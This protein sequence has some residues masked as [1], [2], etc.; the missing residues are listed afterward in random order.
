M[1]KANFGLIIGT[2]GFFN[3]KLAPE[4][5]KALLEKLDKLGYV[6]VTLDE[7]A[8]PYGAVETVEN[9]KK[10]TGRCPQVNE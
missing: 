6:Y 5:R 7:N 9:A 2:R 8:T 10:C 1:K 3:P 4:A